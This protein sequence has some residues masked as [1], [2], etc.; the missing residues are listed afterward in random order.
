MAYEIKPPLWGVKPGK[1]ETRQ[2]VITGLNGRQISNPSVVIEPPYFKFNLKRQIVDSVNQ[3]FISPNMQARDFTPFAKE[4]IDTNTVVLDKSKGKLFMWNLP[5]FSFE[6]SQRANW[7]FTKCGTPPLEIKASGY[8]VLLTPYIY[9]MG[10][11]T[12]LSLNNKLSNN[13]LYLRI[14]YTLL[15]W[16]G[17]TK[18]A[19]RV[20]CACLQEVICDTEITSDDY[21]TLQQSVNYSDW[22]ATNCIQALSLPQLLGAETLQ[23][24]KNSFFIQY[25]GETLPAEVSLNQVFY[26]TLRPNIFQEGISAIHARVCLP[27][28]FASVADQPAI[29][30]TSAPIISGCIVRFVKTT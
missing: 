2:Q 23:N 13:S 28:L 4:L 15:G 20:F 27:E 9:L 10:D 22:S 5:S 6:I 17:M 25:G 1:R 7:N 29:L 8:D 14:S 24:Y 30:T 26:T 12:R 21:C 19:D 11:I 16:K 18:V 3:T